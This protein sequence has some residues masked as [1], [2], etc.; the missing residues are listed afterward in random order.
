MSRSWRGPY[1]RAAGSHRARSLSRRVFDW[2]LAI[3]I[4]GLLILLA[5]RLDRAEIRLAGGSVIVNDGDTITLSGKRI[6][7]RGIDAPEYSQSCRK[8]GSD[9]SCGR[10]S[11]DALARLA[12]RGSVICKGRQHDRYGRLLAD[13]TAAGVDLNGAQVES[14]WAI[15]YGDFE[16]EQERARKHGAGLWAGSFDDPRAWRDAHGGMVESDDD[17]GRSI[18]DW[19]RR[20]LRF[21]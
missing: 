5:A 21:S 3:A 7:L 6:R 4:L 10:A 1:R 15:A 16:P 13:C 9:Y 14:G 20:I 12:G 18:L 17:H 19:L 2:F 8:A 11:R